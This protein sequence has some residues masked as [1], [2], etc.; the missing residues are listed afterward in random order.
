MAVILF[1]LEP[2]RI[3]CYFQGSSGASPDKMDPLRGVYLTHRPGFL[4]SDMADNSRQVVHMRDCDDRDIV[5]SVV[6]MSGHYDGSSRDH[7][8]HIYTELDPRYEVDS[9]FTEEG[10][11]SERKEDSV[12]T[13]SSYDSNM[14]YNGDREIKYNNHGY[15]QTGGNNTRTGLRNQTRPRY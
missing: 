15:Q 12:Y 14:G 6:P 8:G 9:G 7:V 5:A 11:W 1:L 13:W 4:L 2:N 3:L 10:S